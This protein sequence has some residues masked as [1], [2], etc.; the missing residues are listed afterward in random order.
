MKTKE[1]IQLL[2]NVKWYIKADLANG[3]R[4]FGT[5]P[6][7]W[8]FQIYCNGP[9]EHY[10]DLACPFGKTNS[11]LEFCPSVSLFAKSAA[12]RYADEVGGCKPNLGSYVDD[13]I[14][15]FP[16]CDQYERSCHFRTQLCEKGKSLT[17][18]LTSEKK[19]TKYCGRI[20]EMLSAS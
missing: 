2:E 16:F 1:R 15:G 5:H 4:Q 11:P 8:I 18:C 17:V 3:F 14:G 20:N 13:I 12:Q 7:D 10:I 19:V 6:K 9:T